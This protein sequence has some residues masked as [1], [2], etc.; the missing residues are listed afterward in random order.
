MSAVLDE[1]VRIRGMGPGDIDDVVRIEGAAYDFPWSTGVFRECLRAGYV[2]RICL[3]GREAA[4]YGIMT[5][6]TDECHIMNLCVDPARH[7]NGYG[8]MLLKD[9]L[10]IAGRANCHVAFLEV[11]TSNRRA[12]ALYQSMG[13]NEVGVRK[14]YYPA[15]RGREDAYVL[16]R[17]LG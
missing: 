5:L 2:C 8:G 7:G 12:H 9:L 10:A 4:G 11:R 3:V 1:S 17:N 16:A 6:G 15:R 13:F 14:N